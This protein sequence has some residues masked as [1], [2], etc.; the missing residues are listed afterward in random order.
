VY[1]IRYSK[2]GVEMEGRRG[3]TCKSIETWDANGQLASATIE[4]GVDDD[5]GGGGGEMNVTT[6]TAAAAADKR[7]RLRADQLDRRECFYS[8]TCQ[9]SVMASMYLVHSVACKR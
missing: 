8:N 5:D 7:T 4:G 3:G 1:C 9:T 2:A 6:R